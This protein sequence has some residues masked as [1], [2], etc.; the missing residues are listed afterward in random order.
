MDSPA[1]IWEHGIVSPIII[2]YGG[3]Q[4]MRD[5][6]QLMAEYVATSG[7]APEDF[8]LILEKPTKLP[9]LGV[10]EMTRTGCYLGLYVN[11][12]EFHDG[13]SNML[14]VHSITIEIDDSSDP[15]RMTKAYNSIRPT[16]Q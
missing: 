1:N 13:V 7:N 16:L 6:V 15:M 11:T 4:L 10:E 12:R 9:V 2:E 14:C 3:E 8:Y 5:I